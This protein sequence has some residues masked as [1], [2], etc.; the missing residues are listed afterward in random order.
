MRYAG[1][2]EPQPIVA[3]HVEGRA[4]AGRPAGKRA[5]SVGILAGCGRLREEMRAD[6]AGIGKAQARQETVAGA[7]RIDRGE[8]E[9]ARV[10]ADQGERPVLGNR[11]V[12]FGRL[13]GARGAVRRSL[14]LQP[15]DRKMRQP[16]GDDPTH[17]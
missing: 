8:D 12:R 11:Y 3:I 1:D 14:P 10:A 16:H 15:L 5:Q 13:R 9:P 17:D 6:G 2:V 7:P 4:I